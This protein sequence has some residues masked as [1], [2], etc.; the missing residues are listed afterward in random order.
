MATMC[1]PRLICFIG[2]MHRRNGNFCGVMS[3]MIRLCNIRKGMRL[4]YALWFYGR[5]DAHIKGV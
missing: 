2:V 3:N 4:D 5:D 1:A